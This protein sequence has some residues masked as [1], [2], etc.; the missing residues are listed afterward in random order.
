LVKKAIIA[1]KAKF[2]KE[3]KIQ[4]L[5]ISEDKMQAICEKSNEINTNEP[6]H[7]VKLIVDVDET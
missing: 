1:L 6:P 3:D 7:K 2:P 4:Q 5:E